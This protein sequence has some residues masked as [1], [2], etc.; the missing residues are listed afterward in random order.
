MGWTCRLRVY[1]RTRRIL[2]RGLFVLWAA[3]PPRTG[4]DCF[5]QCPNTGIEQ[6]RNG[7]LI[8][9]FD[10]YGARRNRIRQANRGRS[11]CLGTDRA[12]VLMPDLAAFSNWLPFYTASSYRHVGNP[13]SQLTII[14]F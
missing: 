2:R 6:N 8:S 4:N 9:S 3:S 13:N 10:R 11:D 7:I 14:P 5:S 12:L 1:G